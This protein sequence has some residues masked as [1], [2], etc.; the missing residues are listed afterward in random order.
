MIQITLSDGRTVDVHDSTNGDPAPLTIVWHH[1]SPQTG[2]ALEPHLQAAAKRGI[3]WVSYARPSYGE[4]SAQNGRLVRDAAADVAQITDQLAIARFAVMGAS[5]GGPHALACA[6]LLGERVTAVATFASLSPFTTAFDWFAGMADGGQ[7][8]R[9][10]QAG[11][12]ARAE[13]ELTAEFDENSFNA[14]DYAAL[15]SGWRSLGADVGVASSAGFEGLI[16]DDVAFVEQ[17]GVDLSQI[18]SPVLLAQGGDDRVV[19]PPHAQW[20]L[21]NVPDAELWLR[22]RDGHIAILDT[23]IL[24]LDW[25]ASRAH[26]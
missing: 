13:F 16:A 19:P 23:S 26:P 22:P 18:V 1:G 25:I 7:S 11:L 14:R 12:D 6:A 17:W 8:L 3:R 2:A 9:A 10:A 4:S 5:G 20:L 21:E 15:T 24:A